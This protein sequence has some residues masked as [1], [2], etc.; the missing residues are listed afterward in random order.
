MLL[1]FEVDQTTYEIDPASILNTEAIAVQKVTGY[2]YDEWLGKCDDGDPQAVTAM[3]WV[4]MKRQNPE[5]RYSDV[6]FPMRETW[7]NRELVSDEETPTTPAEA[8]QT[9]SN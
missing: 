2:G 1:R 9:E 4:A 3:V 5:L 7:G 8:G 6:S